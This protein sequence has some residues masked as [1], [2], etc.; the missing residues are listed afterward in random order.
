MGKWDGLPLVNGL[1]V[2]PVAVLPNPKIECSAVWAYTPKWYF[3]HGRGHY[4][5]Q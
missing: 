3:L 4:P 1:G 5:M 2:F